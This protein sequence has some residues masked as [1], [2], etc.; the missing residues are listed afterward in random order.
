[1]VSSTVSVS[2]PRSGVAPNRPCHE[3]RS[4]TRGE[5][6]CAWREYVRAAEGTM[7][8]QTVRPSQDDEPD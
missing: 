3:A 7:Y 4:C 2:S 8:M 5:I 1:M 6:V